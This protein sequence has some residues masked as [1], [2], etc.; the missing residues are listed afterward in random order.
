MN[1]REQNEL[2]KWIHDV[3]MSDVTANQRMIDIKTEQLVRLREGGVYVHNKPQKGYD[4][5]DTGNPYIVS[6]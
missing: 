3:L 1:V 4:S 5:M 6:I 2:R